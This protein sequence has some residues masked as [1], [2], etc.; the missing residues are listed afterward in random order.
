MAVERNSS[1]H[2]EV[3]MACGNAMVQKTPFFPKA[4][5]PGGAGI[6]RMPRIR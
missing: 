6:Q 1:S 3:R 5:L 4:K 2:V